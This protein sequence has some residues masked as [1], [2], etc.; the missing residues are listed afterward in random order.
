MYSSAS[1]SRLGQYR[2]YKDH[3]GGIEVSNKSREF[4]LRIFRPAERSFQI[5]QRADIELWDVRPYDAG[6]YICEVE[7]MQD[8]KAHGNGTWLHVSANATQGAADGG[9]QNVLFILL[10]RTVCYGFGLILTALASIVYFWH[11]EV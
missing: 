7:L 11:K 9:T 4:H 2:W 5:E 8:G 6:I 1:G 10:L 3:V